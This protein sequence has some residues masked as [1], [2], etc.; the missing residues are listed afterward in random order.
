MN[1]LTNSRF[2]YICPLKSLEIISYTISK[3]NT[4]LW[5]RRMTPLTKIQIY[6]AFVRSTITYAADAWQLNIKTI[7]KLN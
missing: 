5:D 3:L 4:V 6:H 2:V 1:S 7:A